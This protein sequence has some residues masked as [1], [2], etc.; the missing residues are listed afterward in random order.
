M[1]AGVKPVE[2]SPMLDPV[3]DAQSIIAATER[4]SGVSTI[5]ISHGIDVAV[6]PSGKSVVSLKPF[7]DQYAAAPDRITGTATL[8]DEASFV[9]HVIQMRMSNTRIFANPD[10]SAPSLT[11]VYDY[12]AVDGETQEPAFGVHRAHWPLALSKEWNAW[13]GA[14]GKSMS[15]TEFAKFLEK[16][17]P[18]VY[19]GDQH[20][21]YTK[22][23]I[24]Q[25]ELRLATP[26]SLIALSR[27][28][29]VNVDVQVRQAQTLASGEIA[30]T[31]V[32]QHKDGE[33]QPIKVPNAFLIAIPV[34]L[35]GPAYQLLARLRYRIREGKV[36]WAYDLHRTDLAFDA[37]VKEI[38]ERVQ[39]ETDRTVFL[40]SPEK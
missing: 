19:W 26:S 28:L 27:N 18:D 10:A 23:L 39:T 38:C 34:I 40:G 36:S 4:L 37:A 33:G 9:E 3:S 15:P 12:H 32:E 5:E 16:H 2:L 35:G 25:L 13:T 14:A 6:V 20:S 29:A 24:A 11:A 1:S 21:D 31:Y 22:M 7:L 30:I 17:V 8:R